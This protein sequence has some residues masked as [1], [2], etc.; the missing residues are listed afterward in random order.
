[1]Q[2]K[3]SQLYVHLTW[4]TWNR[5]PLI[6][7]Q[8]ESELYAAIAKKCRQLECEPVA[9]DGTEDHI[10]LLASLHPNISASQLVKD[11]KGSPSHLITHELA[12]D[13]FFKWQ[14]G[15]GVF[16]VSKDDLQKVRAYI[17]NQKKHHQEGGL[18]Q[19][20]EI[21]ISERS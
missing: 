7:E 17:K 2:S 9:I 18:V 8:I 19:A 15:Y 6:N 3:Y 13:E 11:I 12:P 20:W 1:M 21:P 14:G 5:L 10:H 16:S 4:S